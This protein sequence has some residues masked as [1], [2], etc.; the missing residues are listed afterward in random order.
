MHQVCRALPQVF[1]ALVL[2]AVFAT[3]CAIV[4]LVFALV[5]IVLRAFLLV[6]A[7]AAPVFPV[8]ALVAMVSQAFPRVCMKLRVALLEMNAMN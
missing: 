7:L 2:G 3:A 5:A 1:L 4:L 8:F 6:L